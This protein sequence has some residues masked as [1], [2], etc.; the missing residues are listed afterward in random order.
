VGNIRAAHRCP[1]RGAAA[2]E[3]ALVAPLIFL[4]LFAVIEFGRG[5]MVIHGLQTASRDACRMAIVWQPTSEELETAVAERMSSFGISDYTLT[6]EPD[7]ISSAEQWEPI[8]VQIVV[9]YTTASW[10]P[11]PRFLN[12]VNFSGTCVLPRESDDIE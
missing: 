10:L 12:S 7:P 9:P 6:I 4:C 2:I 11:A 8:S 5:I 1:R 3:F